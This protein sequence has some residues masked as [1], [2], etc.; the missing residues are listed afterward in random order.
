MKAI[1]RKLGRILW[2]IILIA[3]LTVIMKQQQSL[4][5]TRAAAAGLP[6]GDEVTN[7]ELLPAGP[8]GLSPRTLGGQDFSFIFVFEEPCFPCNNNIPFWNRIQ[9]MVRGRAE[10]LGILVNSGS[11]ALKSIRR[12]LD[13]DLFM[14]VDP[15]AF[16][17]ALKMDDAGSAVTLFLRKGR[18]MALHRG[19]FRGD[20]F[21]RFVNICKEKLL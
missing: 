13:F 5:R 16:S 10:C 11:E 4:D 3:L 17:L 6:I 18:V 20:G 7:I 12:R 15:Q 9:R 21:A 1:R 19:N 8:S 14:P 2:A